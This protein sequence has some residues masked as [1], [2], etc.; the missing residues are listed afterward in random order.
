M[1]SRPPEMIAPF[2]RSTLIMMDLTYKTI[3]ILWHRIVESFAW[4]S[5][6]HIFFIKSYKFNLSSVT[7]LFYLVQYTFL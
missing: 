5:T 7:C 6:T 3:L 4:G 1:K 2:L